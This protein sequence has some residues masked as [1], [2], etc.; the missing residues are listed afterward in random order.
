[1]AIKL[2]LNS[3]IL[4]IEFSCFFLP[5]TQTLGP[6]EEQSPLL[7]LHARWTPNQQLIAEQ[8]S[9]SSPLWRK[10]VALPGLPVSPI[11]LPPLPQLPPGT[12]PYDFDADDSPPMS[13]DEFNRELARYRNRHFSD[14]DY[15]VRSLR[16][17]DKVD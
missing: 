15:S 12:E 10:S 13:P 5:F 2:V 1:M 11:V 6:L 17:H 7:P 8:I 14:Y 16:S 3:R 4:K 9:A